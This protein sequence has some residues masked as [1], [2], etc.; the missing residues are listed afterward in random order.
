[1]INEA[2]AV[3]LL[4][5]ERIDPHDEA[6]ASNEQSMLDWEGHII[7]PVYRQKILLSEIPEGPTSGPLKTWLSQ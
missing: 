5:P 6:Y 4:T 2:E 7:E 1:M 3:L